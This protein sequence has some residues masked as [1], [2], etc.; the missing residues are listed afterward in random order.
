MAKEDIKFFYPNYQVFSQELVFYYDFQLEKKF[1]ANPDIINKNILQNQFYACAPNSK[2]QKLYIMISFFKRVLLPLS[3]EEL[4]SSTV[5]PTLSSIESQLLEWLY[6]NYSQLSIQ[7]KSL[8]TSSSNLFLLSMDSN[9]R[10]RIQ[11]FLDKKDHVTIISE[12]RKILNSQFLSIAK[13]LIIDWGDSICP[14]KEFKISQIRPELHDSSV[15]KFSI[16]LEK[17]NLKSSIQSDLSS[18]TKVD[19]AENI[20]QKV[21]DRGVTKKLEKKSQEMSTDLAN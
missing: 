7:S 1:S 18:A 11:S 16:W 13:K 21:I 15:T 2:E 20:I 8:T 12:T 10:D 19:K 17:T 6:L 14:S 9:E 5:T 3:Q 4:S